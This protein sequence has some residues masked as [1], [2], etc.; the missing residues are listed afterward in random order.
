MSAEETQTR[1]GVLIAAKS[2]LGRVKLRQALKADDYIIYEEAD[3]ERIADAVRNHKPDLVCLGYSASGFPE[4]S[5]PFKLKHMDKE[6]PPKIVLV[7]TEA[8]WQDEFKGRGIDGFLATPFHP[9]LALIKLRA[10]LGKI[11]SSDERRKVLNESRQFE[12]LA[13][14]DV[15]MKIFKPVSEVV[16][17]TEFSQLGLKAHTEKL[18]TGHVEQDAHV[19]LT[20]KGLSMIMDARITMVAEGEVSMAFLKKPPSFKSFFDTILESLPA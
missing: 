15:K 17:V 8:E 10:F 5:L 19:Q 13:V 2:K 20:I 11:T 18:T 16:S 12:H 6:H 4:G 9:D 3:P 1:Q 7:A 14:T